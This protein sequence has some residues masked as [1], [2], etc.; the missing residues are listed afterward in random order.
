MK[1]RYVRT[2]T[3]K[4]LLQVTFQYHERIEEMPPQH[5]V[6]CSLDEPNRN[7]TPWLAYS[8]WHWPFAWGICHPKQIY[9][10]SHD[11]NPSSLLG[12]PAA[13]SRIKTSSFRGKMCGC[14]LQRK[15][16]HQQENGH[17]WERRKQQ[18]APTK[19][20]DGIDRRE[21]KQKVDEAKPEGS[22]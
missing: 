20:V 15:A 3:S 21:G 18:I 5:T 12:Y 7:K 13:Y 6:D 11:G 17:Q 16:S 1:G 2:R 9:P 8:P 10:K 14:D 19:R 22:Q 4:R